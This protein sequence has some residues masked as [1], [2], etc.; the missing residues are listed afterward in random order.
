M[1]SYSITECIGLYICQSI[2]YRASGVRIKR[3]RPNNLKHVLLSLLYET[4]PNP[5]VGTRFCSPQWNV[6]LLSICELILSSRYVELVVKC[7]E[8]TSDIVNIT[9]HFVGL[10][11]NPPVVSISG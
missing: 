3:T 1:T 7:L 11:D 2:A 5:P 9:I 8:S 4:G 6:C 10:N